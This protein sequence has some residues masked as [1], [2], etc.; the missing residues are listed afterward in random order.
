MLIGRLHRKVAGGVSPH[1]AVLTYGRKY[2]NGMKTSRIFNHISFKTYIFLLRAGALKY[3][4][5][6]KDAPKQTT[7][8]S[9]K[10]TAE[11]S[12]KNPTL[13]PLP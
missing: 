4:T 6:K 9:V 10:A 8:P 5:L 12:F 13:E 11:C 1:C 3:V 7:A 2:E